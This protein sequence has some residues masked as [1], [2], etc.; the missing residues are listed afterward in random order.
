MQMAFCETCIK[1]YKRNTGKKYPE[2]NVVFSFETL[3]ISILFF[4]T[5]GGR[6]MLNTVVLYFTNILAGTRSMID[7]V[8]ISVSYKYSY[9]VI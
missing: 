4:I 6:A 7:H 9:F 5:I 1:L 8:V 3:L 2:N